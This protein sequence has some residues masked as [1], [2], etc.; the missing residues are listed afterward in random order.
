MEIKIYKS[1]LENNPNEPLFASGDVFSL[2]DKDETISN[3]MDAFRSGEVT[4]FINERRYEGKD[5]SY[6]QVNIRDVCRLCFVF[7]NNNDKENIISSISKLK[8]MPI[9][10]DEEKEA[11]VKAVF[12]LIKPFNPIFALCDKYFSFIRESLLGE[13]IPLLSR[14]NFYE[15]AE[16]APAPVEEVKAEPAVE[17]VKAIEEVE[18]PKEK[19]HIFKNFVAKF[20]KKEDKVVIEQKEEKVPAPKKEKK[21]LLSNEK[22]NLLID[23]FYVV[24]M[25]ALM[26]IFLFIAI[27]FFSKDK[28]GLGA[29]IIVVLVIETGIFGYGL[30][31]INCENNNHSFFNKSKLILYGINLGGLLLGFLLALLVGAAV[32]KISDNGYMISIA[33]ICLEAAFILSIVLHIIAIVLSQ[34]MENRKIKK[35]NKRKE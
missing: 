34:Y 24:S 4:F 19:K 25:P 29:F 10:T 14:S 2:S 11:K 17:E 33:F 5:L 12:E 3:L 23:I 20:K 18:V 28:V 7:A 27:D 22:K 16:E 35:R 30:Y 9:E 31:L 15:V 6:S 8:G 26:L 21:Q 13:N 1:Y 32:L